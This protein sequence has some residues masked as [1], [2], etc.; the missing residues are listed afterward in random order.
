[1]NAKTSSPPQTKLCVGERVVDR[2]HPW[3]GLRPFTESTQQFF[4]GRDR[5]IADLFVRIRENPLTVL[6]GQ[7]GLGKT[8]L[9]GAGLVPKLRIEGYCLAVIRLRF[10]SNEESL[11]AQTRRALAECM[12]HP[13]VADGEATL[14][15]SLHRVTVRS[16]LEQAMPVIVFDQFEEVFTLGI[17]EDRRDEVAELVEQ[18]ADLVQ[19]RPPAALQKRFGENRRLAADF[20]F[21]ACAIRILMTLR[22]DFLSHLEQF[23]KQ[24]PSLMRNRMAL[25]ALRGSQALDAVVRPGA[26]SRPALVSE[27]VGSAIVRFVAKRGSDVPLQDIEAVPP[28]VSLVCDE[29]NQLRIQRGHGEITLDLVTSQSDDILQHFYEECFSDV[30]SAV[31][32]LVEDRMV[33]TGGNRYPLPSEDAIHYLR[34]MG[35]ENPDSC[36]RQLIGRRLVQSEDRDGVGWLEITHDVLAPLVVSS[37]DERR[38][39]EQI[40]LAQKA[41]QKARQQRNRLLG[42]IAVFAALLAVAMAAA[43]H[44]SRESK[45]AEI[46][47]IEAKEAEDRAKEEQEKAEDAAQ[48]AKDKEKVARDA[49]AI[50][51]AAEKETQR[52]LATLFAERGRRAYEQWDLERALLHLSASG[53]AGDNQQL[54]LL[55]KSTVDLLQAENRRWVAHSAAVRWIKPSARGRFIATA[56]TRGIVRLW[57]AIDYKLRYTLSLQS[58]EAS[59]I[60]FTDNDE[61]CLIG[62]DTGDVWRYDLADDPKPSA[63]Q[64]PLHSERVTSLQISTD[65]NVAVAA[66]DRLVSVWS[67]EGNRLISKRKHESPVVAAIW[68]EDG[69]LVSA[70]EKGEVSFG[71][72]GGKVKTTQLTTDVVAAFKVRDAYILTVDRLG[73]LR[74]LDRTGAIVADRGSLQ[75]GRIADVAWNEES[76]TLAMSDEFG[77]AQR[78]IVDLK[79]P[80]ERETAV[81]VRWGAAALPVEWN[82]ATVRTC[83][84][85]VTRTGAI[86]CVYNNGGVAAWDV[87]SNG[88]RF[89]T[90]LRSQPTAVL[91]LG[92]RSLVSTDSGEI[93]EVELKSRTKSQIVCRNAPV[94]FTAMAVAPDKRSVTVWGTGP[95]A[96]V[97][98][99]ADDTVTEL[100]HSNDESRWITGIAYSSDGTQIYSSDDSSVRIWRLGRPIER[101]EQPLF[102]LPQQDTPETESGSAEF[103]R[104]VIKDIALSEPDNRLLILKRKAKGK[105]LSS[106]V[107]SWIE[108]HAKTGDLLRSGRETVNGLGLHLVSAPASPLFG[109]TTERGVQIIRRQSGDPITHGWGRVLAASPDG[110]W[111]AIG[112]SNGEIVLTMNGSTIQE[113]R[114]ASGHES[115]TTLEF[116]DNGRLVSAGNKGSTKVWDMYGNKVSELQ[117][118]FDFQ[119][120]MTAVGSTTDG[121]FVVAGRENGVVELFDV[122]TGRLL[123]SDQLHDGVVSDVVTLP[124]FQFA[125]AGWDGTVRMTSYQGISANSDAVRQALSR[126]LPPESELKIEEQRAWDLLLRES[127]DGLEQTLHER[128]LNEADS[129]LAAAR[130]LINPKGQLQRESQ[131][132]GAAVVRH[133]TR[134]ISQWAPSGHAPHPRVAASPDFRRFA[135]YGE[136]GT[137]IV[138]RM[139]E[140]GQLETVATH[141]LESSVWDAEFSPDGSLIATRGFSPTIH[142][143][144]SK[145]GQRHRSLTDHRLR[146]GSISWTGTGTELISGSRD[147]TARIW[148]SL[149]SGQSLVLPGHSEY[150]FH[151]RANQK[152][153]VTASQSGQIWIWKRP[154]LQQPTYRLELK[155]QDLSPLSSG[156]SILLSH[157]GTHVYTSHRDGYLRKWDVEAGRLEE[158]VKLTD[159]KDTSA[160][161]NE[162]PTTGEIIVGGLDPKAHFVFSSESLTVPSKRYVHDAAVYDLS[163]LS[164]NGRY[165]LTKTL[166]D[167]LYL[168]DYQESRLLSRGY[169]FRSKLPG[170]ISDDG[171]LLIEGSETGDIMLLNPAT[172]HTPVGTVSL[173]ADFETTAISPDGEKVACPFTGGLQIAE[174]QPTGGQKRVHSLVELPEGLRSL[175][176]SA[177]STTLLAEGPEEWHV[178]GQRNGQWSEVYRH[179][180]GWFDLADVQPGMTLGVDQRVE[181]EGQQTTSLASPLHATAWKN[182]EH[183]SWLFVTQERILLE[184]SLGSDG[185]ASL[186]Y[187]LPDVVAVAAARDG[188]V[189]W[190]DE[191]GL[192]L[193]QDFSTNEGLVPVKNGNGLLWTPN[194]EDLLV[195]KPDG[196]FSFVDAGKGVI[197]WQGYGHRTEITS[198]TSSP[199]SSLLFTVDRIGEGMLYDQKNGRLIAAIPSKHRP[200]AS[201]VFNAADSRALV[202]DT[203]GGLRLF[204]IGNSGIEGK[205][206]REGTD[207]S[208][209]MFGSWQNGRVTEITRHGAVLKWDVNVRDLAGDQK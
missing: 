152:Y 127:S 46:A 35:V 121:S 21:D 159:K 185:K 53:V 7:S 205:Q 48:Q 160:F 26:L 194:G 72:Q 24:M 109:I 56:D 146:I 170:V 9:I 36:I 143:F 32:H 17:H 73:G 116:V 180:V 1:M 149:E 204:D 77:A 144:D 165:L 33:T 140:A 166:T 150:V 184:M 132:R 54:R 25:H 145:T 64:L 169:G 104:E 188:R 23:K 63:I 107:T 139:N 8:S 179:Q 187:V 120:R 164:S 125:S 29:L 111:M 86:H 62:D 93:I 201:A 28:L 66:R 167:E 176:W 197:K 70:S 157:D 14:W 141:A 15:E 207:S 44:A 19:N 92:N 138:W 42:V 40:Q 58:G 133:L 181:K 38:E 110:K 12:D 39:R 202:F 68:L 135:T 199:S 106:A 100:K 148:P 74:L 208:V 78:L 209:P 52:N 22:E 161:L 189:A 85:S 154:D 136:D 59:A 153:A 31:R 51:L 16:R 131:G 193:G 178:V 82:D 6:Y 81:T 130:K 171:S 83:S 71:S 117:S 94:R 79:A 50:A 18:I 115:V 3:L 61:T 198:V 41:I 67:L 47:R 175:T 123:L 45:S 96:F 20:Y 65:G 90:R 119:A 95:T 129:P 122:S 88:L 10:Q 4:F 87:N 156:G 69:L 76:S 190:L 192:H 147:E 37:R 105:T 13:D 2:E 137:L 89:R 177:D 162:H 113:R 108:I 174:L 11:L 128:K 206:V 114:W 60:A 27:N 49:E 103:G 168:W 91:A 5:E 55:L 97:I 75:S 134:G 99:I 158:E 112:S 182:K 34:S 142:I 203:G 98:S 30:P 195:T 163:T 155:H 126:H 151:A 101:N 84:L 80:S 124:D 196:S 200:I 118:P 183:D 186:R 102:V 191:S 173:P 43:F 172:M 57:D